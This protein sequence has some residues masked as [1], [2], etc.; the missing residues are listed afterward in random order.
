VNPQTTV[1]VY[2]VPIDKPSQPDLLKLRK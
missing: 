2:G 1:I